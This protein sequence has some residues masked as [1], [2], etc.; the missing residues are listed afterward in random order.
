VWK[1]IAEDGVWS[2]L[3]INALCSAFVSFASTP[4]VK[5]NHQADEAN[6]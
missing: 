2:R 5:A 4:A 6:A 1:V 3:K